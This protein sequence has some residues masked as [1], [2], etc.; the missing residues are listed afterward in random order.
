MNETKM[1]D[2]LRK[3]Y[4]EGLPVTVSK[5]WFVDTSIPSEIEFRDFSDLLA[6][7]K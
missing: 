6:R 5:I 3:A 7:A 1:L 4:P 2:A